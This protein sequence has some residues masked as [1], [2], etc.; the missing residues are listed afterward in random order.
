[1]EFKNEA[2]KMKVIIVGGVA[3]GASCAARLRR[4]NEKAEI[5]MVERGPYVSYANCGLPYH[6]GEV[7]AKE[8]SLLVANERLFREHFAI[9]VRTRCEA[10]AI[11]PQNKTVQLKNV[12]TGEVT[13][14]A[15]DKPVLSPGAPS[16]RPP[17]P[18]IDLSGIF[19]YG[20]C[21][22]RARF[23]SGLNRARPFSRGCLRTRGSRW[24][25]PRGGRWSSA[26]VLSVSRWRKTWSTSGS[27]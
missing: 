19:P 8:S 2:K 4:L 12:E 27:R 7:I 14:E 13:T 24:S 9:D 18:G 21:R 16:V 5:L 26:A 6:V 10:I 22:M 23:V 3:G 15:Y 11:A 1:M 17:L 20:P 25:G